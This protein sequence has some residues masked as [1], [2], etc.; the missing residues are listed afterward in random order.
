[1]IEMDKSSGSAAA[2]CDAP[3]VA[4]HPREREAEEWSQA[5]MADGYMPYRVEDFDANS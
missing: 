1:M 4:G 3:I 5:L 2:V